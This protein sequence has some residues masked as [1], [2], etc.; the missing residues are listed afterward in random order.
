MMAAEMTGVQ[1][2]LR[3]NE[4]MSKHTSWRVGG[5]ADVH[6]TPADRDD[7]CAF[8]R[9]H[10]PAVPLTWVGLG[11][12]LLV[13][14]GGVR[15]VVIATHKCLGRIERRGDQGLYIEAGVPGAK[16]ARFSVRQDLRGAEFFAGIP[17]T[18]GGA[19]AMNAGAFGSET[20]DVVRAVETVDG[21]GIERRRSPDEY[22]IGYRTV[23][24]PA[25]GEWY[26]AAQ[27]ELHTGDGEVG[28]QQIKELLSKRAQSQPIQIPNAGSVF[29]NPPGDYAARLIEVA[30]LKGTTR[31][32]A[33]VSPRHANFIVNLGDARAAD[34]EWLIDRVQE[35]VRERHGVELEREVRIVG[36][37]S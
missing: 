8:L 29:R 28:R 34:I 5:P 25:H 24:P 26:I 17:G 35:Q 21:Q 7:L 23:V 31:G 36:E 15:G 33:Q 22:Q 4:P 30:G 32:R 20:W 6:F 18:L 10:D 1:G 11:S 13:R 37:T 12:N 27:I 3:T 16:I 14:D 19:L 9:H 2:E